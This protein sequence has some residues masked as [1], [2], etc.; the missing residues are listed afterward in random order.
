[1]SKK[2]RNETALLPVKPRPEVVENSPNDAITAEGIFSPEQCAEIVERFGPKVEPAMVHASATSDKP[3]PREEYRKS[4]NTFLNP[5][6]GDTIWVFDKLLQ[7][8]IN[9]NEFFRFEVDHFAAVQFATYETGDYY[10][11]HVD[12]GPGYMGN[13]KLSMTVQL[14]AN[15]DYKG[16]DFLV[17]MDGQ[18][19]KMS[20]E[21]GSV[22]VFPSFMPHKVTEVTEGV[23][24]SLVVWAAGTHRF[25]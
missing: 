3:V 15:N 22:T 23:R 16:G 12:I 9:G 14:T 25:R 4:K 7:T 6:D 1:M 5:E 17:R 8:L 24:H 10:H 19:H 18:W 13:R 2:L 21:I 11:E 20:R